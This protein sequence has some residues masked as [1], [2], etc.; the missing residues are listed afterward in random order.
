[1]DPIAGLESVPSPSLLFDADRIGRN[2]DRLIGMVDGDC[3]LLRP[4]IKTHKCA[5]ILDLQRAIP[6]VKCATIAEAELAAR[7]GVP[8]VLLAY[9]LVGPNVGR[10]FTLIEKYGDTAFSTVIDS[11]IGLEALEAGAETE[12]AVFIDLDC[13]MH[14]TGIAPGEEALSLAQRIDRS[15]ELKFAGVHA[16]DGHIHDA[17]L[18]DRKSRFG[19]AVSQVDAFLEQLRDAGIEV[20]L[21]V[22]G[23]SPTFALH[24]DR[25]ENSATKW[26]CSPGTTL[27]WDAG[28]GEHYPDLEFE[29]AAFLLTRV[30]SRPGKNRLC[31][32]LGHKAVSAEN[33]IENRVR[34]PDLPDVKFES[35]SEEHLV[36]STPHAE[37]WPVGTSLVGLPYHV[38]PTVALHQHA[39]VIRNGKATG[40]KWAI[41]A[42]DR[43]LSI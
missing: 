31:V 4:H 14:R 3:S 8:D 40:E 9:P 21:V 16:Y 23:G 15:D 13:G 42:R 36:L 12:L 22:S 35:Q 20:P 17:S 34:F 7:E 29:A 19:A 1:M 30:V 10:L 11:D 41:A 37:D 18:E 39:H 6:R 33:P 28:Y 24:A 32:D 26:Q 2:I 38:C 25:A 27:L 43:E 5:E